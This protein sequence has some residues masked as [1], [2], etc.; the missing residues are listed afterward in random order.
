MGGDRKDLW[1]PLHSF[2]WCCLPHSSAASPV[3]LYFSFPVC[4]TSI[5]H[6]PFRFP[7]LPVSSTSGS[8][9]EASQEWSGSTPQNSKHDKGNSGLD[10]TWKYSWK[11]PVIPTAGISVRKLPQVPH[12]LNLLSRD[13]LLPKF[14]IL[15]YMCESSS[16]SWVH[17]TP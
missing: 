16:Y 15:L 7:P 2:H 17:Q 6:C 11:T 9:P 4:S 12:P 14:L 3:S 10:C 8:I 5:P 1:L 13:T